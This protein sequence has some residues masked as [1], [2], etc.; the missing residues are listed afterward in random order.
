MTTAAG[1]ETHWDEVYRTKGD[2][3]VSWFEE[4]P[5]LSIEL[6]GANSSLSSAIVDI[7]G[8]ASRLPDTLLAGGYTDVTVLDISA[9]ALAK[10]RARV[11]A[12]GGRA[13]WIVSDVTRWQPERRYDVWHDRAAF[14][15][16]TDPAD[17]AAYAGV[18]AAALRSGGTAIIATFAPDGPEKCSGLPVVRHDGSSVAAVLGSDFKLE[19]EL[20][21][22]HH[23]PW[24]S[25][26]RFQFSVFRRA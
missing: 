15:F 21:H 6:I 12:A 7:G 3:D 2:S 10:A 26:Q 20:R 19:R 13:D 1:R 5:H 18:L 9:E 11:E 8:G 16:L 22:E 24:G 17:Q 25:V 23:T 14:H 4:V